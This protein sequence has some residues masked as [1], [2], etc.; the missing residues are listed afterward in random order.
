MVITTAAVTTTTTT[1]TTYYV[2][3]VIKKSLGD[4][5]GLQI[6]SRKSNSNIQIKTVKE[7]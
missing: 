5:E 1:T 4:S 7:H 2:N 3:N 6:L